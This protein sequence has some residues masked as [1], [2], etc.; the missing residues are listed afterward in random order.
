M[1][2]DVGTETCDGLNWAPVD[3]GEH[4]ESSKTPAILAF[5]I[6]RSVAMSVAV[7]SSEPNSSRMAAVHPGGSAVRGHSK[8]LVPVARLDCERLPQSTNASSSA[9]LPVLSPVTKQR[10]VDVNVSTTTFAC[11]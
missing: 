4:A 9:S 3:S 6:R 8:V 2:A 1:S 5:S 10:H 11:S 7:S